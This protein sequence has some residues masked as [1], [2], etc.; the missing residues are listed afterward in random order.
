MD[1]E[2]ALLNKIG[3]TDTEAKVYLTLLQNGDLS[4]Y[5]TSKLAGVPRSKI[6]VILECLIQKGFIL[7]TQLENNNKYSALPMSEVAQRVETETKDI[8]SDLTTQLSIFPQ[9]TNLD[10]LWHIHTVSNAFA[11]C[12]EIMKRTKK[13]LLLQIWSDD[14]P[15][16]LESLHEL[17]HKGIPMGIV[18]FNADA[19]KEI[20]LQKYYRHGMTVEKQLEMGGRWITLVSDNKEVVF[21]QIINDTI[22]E[23]IWTESKPMLSLA[24]EYVRHDIYFYKCAKE[25][26]NEMRKKFGEDLENIRNIF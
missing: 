9:R 20:P 23:I 25:L 24:A 6:Y 19:T 3:L 21:G 2:I 26:P 12:R 8:L 1:H 10:D 4:G 14:L 11:K 13:E 16:I 17:E 7:Y 18:V 5:E 22:A 15:Y